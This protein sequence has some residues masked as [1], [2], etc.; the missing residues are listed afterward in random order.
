MR[1]RLRAFQSRLRIF[2]L[3]RARSLPLVRWSI[4]IFAQ[5]TPLRL[6]NVCS[7][8]A[9]SCTAARPPRIR[10]LRGNE[11]PTMGSLSQSLEPRILPWRIIRR[12][13]GRAGGRNDD[14]RGWHRR[15]R[16]DPLALVDQWNLW[17]QAAVRAQP[18]RPGA[19]AGDSPA[20]WPDD[21][22]RRRRSAHAERYVRAASS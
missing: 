7:M 22:Q 2:I 10:S 20:L 5:T 19:S 18:A 9:R 3:L 6:S 17:L 8:L 11:K 16:F 4:E 14:D 21:A 13:G 1:D 12:R 15:R